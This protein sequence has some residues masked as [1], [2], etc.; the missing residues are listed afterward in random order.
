MLDQLKRVARRTPAYRIYQQQRARM[1]LRLWSPLDQAR[2]DF[3]SQFLERGDIAFDVG[4]NMGNRT[5]IFRMLCQNVIAI[6]PQRACVEVLTRAFA[7][8]PHVT[9]VTDALGAEEG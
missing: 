5:R 6:E 3:Y 8:D 4:A 7:A 1:A 2:L 9:L